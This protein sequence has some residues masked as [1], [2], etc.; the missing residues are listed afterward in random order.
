MKKI[1]Q[2]SE[3]QSKKEIDEKINDLYFRGSK[4]KSSDVS[5]VWEKSYIKLKP[6]RIR[7]P[8]LK[9]YAIDDDDYE[10]IYKKQLLN[11]TISFTQLYWSK[12]I[13]RPDYAF[14][15]IRA[16][17]YQKDPCKAYNAL[18]KECEKLLTLCIHENPIINNTGAE[19]Q[20]W[21]I[22]DLQEEV[23]YVLC[24]N[25]R[26]QKY[27]QCLCSQKSTEFNTVSIEAPKPRPN[28][29]FKG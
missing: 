11:E 22:N 14:I 29:R 1:K 27:Y 6:K 5:D 28:P 25:S 17:I 23:D 15:F 8:K 19:A 24:Q 7:I 4:I 10:K 9:A 13:T 16:S 20:F 18:Q 21:R 12:S 3:K 26:F 2:K